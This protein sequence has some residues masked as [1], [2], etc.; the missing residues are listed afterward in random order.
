MSC[1]CTICGKDFP[2][3]SALKKH[4]H[5]PNDQEKNCCPTCQKEIIGKYEETHGTKIVR[6]KGTPQHILQAVKTM[7]GYNSGRAG[8]SPSEELTLRKPRRPTPN[9]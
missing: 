5:R 9:I 1:L 7:T 8:F 6:K 3:E 4:R 2:S